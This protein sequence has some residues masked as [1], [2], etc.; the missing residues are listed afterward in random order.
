[1]AKYDTICWEYLMKL[2]NKI[3]AYIVFGIV[4]TLVISMYAID[5]VSVLSCEGGDYSD[6]SVAS[7]RNIPLEIIPLLQS[8]RGLTNPEICVMP[9]SKLDRALFRIENPKPDHPGEAAAFRM[10]QNQDENG[11]IPPDAIGR[12]LSHVEKMPSI[13]LV[14]RLDQI[15]TKGI[16]PNGLTPQTMPGVEVETEMN[17]DPGNWAWLGPGNIGGLVRSIVIH[18]PETTRP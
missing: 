11:E 7:S 12:A 14:P 4:F 15:D 5:L 3:S 6:I 8:E 13:S 18:P 9:Q 17:L 16:D 1:M 10:M 2:N